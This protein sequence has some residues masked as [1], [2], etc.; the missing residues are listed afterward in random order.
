MLQE[1]FVKGKVQD[2]HLN[3]YEA[4]GRTAEPFDQ[5]NGL[6]TVPFVRLPDTKID[7]QQ[8][9][10][11]SNSC[12]TS[13]QN[14]HLLPPHGAYCIIK[15]LDGL[16]DMLINKAKI[17]KEKVQKF[18]E[19]IKTQRITDM[20]Y[21][22]PGRGVPNE[23]VA[24]FSYVASCNTD[25]LIKIEKPTIM[26]TLSQNAFYLMITKL[27]IHFLRFGDTVQS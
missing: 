19:D 5:G 25:E 7:K 27:S 12:D 15:S 16:Q 8:V 22:P 3:F 13:S 11:I 4:P 20:M 21:L 10:V 2:I 1:A 18:I 9:L 26:F 17:D 6:D 14:E 23:S 24:M